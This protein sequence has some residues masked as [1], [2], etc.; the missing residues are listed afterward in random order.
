M[1]NLLVEIGTEELPVESLDAVYSELAE[2]AKGAFHK[3]RLAFEK[4]KTEATPRR[5]A[6]FVTALAAR[7]TDLTGEIFGPSFAKAYEEEGRPTPA[8]EGFLKSKNARLEDVLVKETPKGKYVLLRKKEAGRPLVSILPEVL[9]QILGGL[10]FPKTMRW[11]KSGFRFPR[12]IRWI[13]VLLDKKVVSFEMAGVRSHAKTRGHRFLAPRPL[14]LSK[15]DWQGYQKIL[16]R[17]HV[18]LGLEARKDLVRKALKGRFHQKSFDE[19]LVSITAQLVEEPFLIQGSFSKTYLQL[20]QEVL[21]SCM[22]KNQRIFA[23]TDRT[24]RMSGNFVAVLNGKRRG[25]SRIRHDYENVLESRLRDAQYFYH[26]DLQEPLEK[27][28]PLLDQLVYLGKLGTMRQKTERLERLADAFAGLVGRQDLQK[29]LKRAARLSKIDLMTK[30]VYEFP[31]LQGIA[32]REYALESQEKEEVARAIGTQY[33]PKNLAEDYRR[34]GEGLSPLGALF[35]LIDRLDLLVGAFA[36]GLQPTGSQDPYALRRAGGVLV[37]IIRAFRFH[38]PLSEAIQASAELYPKTL[39]IR[40]PELEP[41]LREFL[42]ERVAFELQTKPGARSEEILEAVCRSSFEDLADVYDRTDTLTK[43]SERDS[44]NFLKAAKV[45]E[46]TANILKGIKERRPQ[47]FN[48]SLM[49]EPL[50]R[51][52]FKLYEDRSPEISDWLQRRDYEKA[53][54]VFGNTFYGPLHDFFDHVLVNVE[55]A[56][57]RSNRQALMNKIN[58]LYTDR[59]ADLSILS[60]LN[61]E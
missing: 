61:Q 25:L 13:V 34:L 30:L 54:L 27:K 58:R 40:I 60:R 37:K 28:L 5:I 26:A 57:V 22:K 21:S 56:A 39:G 12:P 3:N 41:P 38:F 16:K 24:G 23:G 10:S 48:P 59:L 4:I 14:L 29:D 55:D 32:G 53:T 44:E 15:A 42:K 7:Q 8:L 52:L 1:P 49:Q 6:L 31:D 46:R 36:S 50:E 33:A 17:L 9:N 45:V 35:G 20:P 47:E 19:E 11:E 43:L 18:I 51:D 2:K